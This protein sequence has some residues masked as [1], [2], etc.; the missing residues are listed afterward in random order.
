MG[1]VVARDLIPTVYTRPASRAPPG[2]RPGF[3]PGRRRGEA[4][5]RHAPVGADFGEARLIVEQVVQAPELRY[6]ASGRIWRS[7]MSCRPFTSEQLARFDALRS[8]LQAAGLPHRPGFTP[9]TRQERSHT[10]RRATTSSAA[11][12]PLRVPALCR[13]LPRADRGGRRWA[14][15]GTEGRP[16][17]AMYEI[18]ARGSRRATDGRTRSGE[19]DIATVPVGYADGVREGCRSGWRAASRR[20]RR[21]VA[22]T[23]TMD[24]LL[25][26]CGPDSGVRCGDES[27]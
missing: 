12:S 9:R 25:V 21:R 6:A 19:A 18:W 4:R 5:Q 13:R 23:V 17:S 14:L 10:R 24:Q 3:A 8:S 20:R 2:G 26:D 16:R 15:R 22:G 11:G 7:Q 27:C 1:E